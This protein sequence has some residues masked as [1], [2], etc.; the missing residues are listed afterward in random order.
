MKN[1]LKA[2]LVF[3]LAAGLLLS[4]GCKQYKIEV[5]MN[6]DGSGMRKVK[7]TAPTIG[8]NNLEI[9]LEKFRQAILHAQIRPIVG[10]VLG[11]QDDLANA[12]IL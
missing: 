1:S 3:G 7:L 9:S 11:D 10:G 5:T 8:D 2:L 12:P 4:A 6:E